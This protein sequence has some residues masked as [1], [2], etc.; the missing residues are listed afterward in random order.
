MNE[1]QF[2][3]STPQQQYCQDLAQGIMQP[4]AAQAGAI[5]ALNQLYLDLMTQRHTKH[6]FGFKRKKPVKGLYLWGGVGRGKTYLMDTFYQLLPF[7]HKQRLHFHR[8]MRQVHQLL[9]SYQGTADP[10]KKVAKAMAAKTRVLCFDEFVVIDIA[11]AMILGKLLTY[12]FAAGVCLVA[13]SNF[14]PDQLYQEGLQRELFLPAI[15]VLQ[16]HMAV[17]QVDSGVDY[18]QQTME[19]TQRYISPLKNELVLMQVH[20]DAVKRSTPRADTLYINNRTLPVIAYATD[21][22]WAEFNVLCDAPRSQLDY[23]DIA[24]QFHYVLLSGVPQMDADQDDKARRFMY[25]VDELYDNGNVLIISAAEAIEALYTGKRLQFEFARTVSRL[26]A[27][28]ALDYPAG[29]R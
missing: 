28:Q 7:K 22:V 12:L 1:A 17:M 15:A 16:Q 5:A 18:R 20:F 25:L 4:D 24:D 13:T 10:L 19:P 3:M 11:D 9:K 2:A 8:F 21:V 23:I 6:W 14:A 27:M 29:V 26:T